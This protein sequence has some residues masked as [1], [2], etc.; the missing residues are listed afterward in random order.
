LNILAEKYFVCLK[1]VLR[2][3]T[4]LGRRRRLFSA[5]RRPVAPYFEGISS[6]LTTTIET[7]KL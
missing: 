6:H 7:L 3:K 4:N 5:K 2:R 1:F